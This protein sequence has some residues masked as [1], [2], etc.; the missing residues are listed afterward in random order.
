[1]RAAVLP[2]SPDVFVE[3][4]AGDFGLKKASP[5]LTRSMARTRSSRGL[6]QDIAGGAGLN[7]AHDIFG[8]AVHGQDEHLDFG[9]L[10]AEQFGD[11]QPVHFGMSMSIRTMSG[12]SSR[13][14]RIASWPS[15][16]SPTI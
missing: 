6:L 5:S 12:I 14:L 8:I 4:G 10:F 9:E 11:G 16:A 7:D 15:S 2:A 1:L 3:R 13:A